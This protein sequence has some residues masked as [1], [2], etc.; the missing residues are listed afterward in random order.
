[1]MTGQAS[2]VCPAT[3]EV[4]KSLKFIPHLN[5]GMSMAPDPAL[6]EYIVG[7]VQRGSHVRTGVE[8][9]K[10]LSVIDRGDVCSYR[11]GTIMKGVTMAFDLVT[12]PH[13]HRYWTN[14]HQY[15]AVFYGNHKVA[16]D[17]LTQALEK[18]K[19]LE[20]KAE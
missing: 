17:L 4:A 14:Q 13:F 10:K 18:S 1:M 11:E 6:G 2:A 3:T 8:A 12:L 19:N 9:P 20:D 15:Q 5:P 16:T 7:T